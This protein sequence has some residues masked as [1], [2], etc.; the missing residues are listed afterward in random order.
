MRK[1]FHLQPIDSLSLVDFHNLA[2]FTMALKSF[3]LLCLVS[4]AR[5]FV[6]TSRILAFP[7]SV[8]VQIDT[9]HSQHVPCRMLPS[10]IMT[11]SLLLSGEPD[12]WGDLMIG[13]GIAAVLC[14]ALVIVKPQAEDSIALTP[15]EEQKEQLEKFGP[16]PETTMEMLFDTLEATDEND[17]SMQEFFDKPG[18]DEWKQL[19]S[20]LKESKQKKRGQQGGEN[21]DNNRGFPPEALA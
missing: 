1:I 3:L 6:P 19:I 10:D 9:L 16:T 20:E 7:R 15:T 2:I 12:M 18:G 4:S 17:P 13:C 14:T 5:A 21:Q 8:S 11:S